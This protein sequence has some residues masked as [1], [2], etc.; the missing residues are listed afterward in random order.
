MGFALTTLEHPI[1][2]YG[3]TAVAEFLCQCSN[4]D[5]VDSGKPWSEAV[6]CLTT[7]SRRRRPKIR[8][9]WGEINGITRGRGLRMPW[10]WFAVPP[11]HA[12]QGENAPSKKMCFWYLVRKLVLRLPIIR[13]KAGHVGNRMA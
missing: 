13:W 10:C 12:P 6:E 7:K 3:P 11:P 8:G 4:Q 2:N 5:L 1:A 9:G